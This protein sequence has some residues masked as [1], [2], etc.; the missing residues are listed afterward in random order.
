MPE[1]I[2]PNSNCYRNSIAKKSKKENHRIH[3]TSLILLACLMPLFVSCSSSQSA[4][5]SHQSAYQ[6]IISSGKIRCGYV[7]YVPGCIKDPNSGKLSGMMVDIVNE[8][9]KSLGLQVE[10]S[11]EVGWGSMIEGL[12]TGRYD[13]VGSGVWANATRG[14]VCGSTVPLFYS[15]LH[16]YVRNDDHRFDHHLEAINSN[17]VRIATTDGEMAAIIAK[18]DFPQAQELALPQL[19]DLSQLLINVETKK[20]D[21]TFQE[22]AATAWY[23]KRNPGKLRCL[24][25]NN[26]IRVFPYVLLTP[27]EDLALKSM[28]DTAIQELINRGY[29]EKVLRKYEIEPGTYYRTVR[30][31]EIKN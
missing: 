14:K 25:T 1:K 23:L 2:C 30:P 16:A 29:V 7:T 22:N 5:V 4:V 26:P 27:L 8:L 21:V 18:A 11:E 24:T 12:N 10:W 17:S 20:A 9:G 6:R 3:I 13:I 28:L 19:S 31:Y 15:G